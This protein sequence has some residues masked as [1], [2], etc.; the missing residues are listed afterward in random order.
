MKKHTIKLAHLVLAIE[1]NDGGLLAR[2]PTIEG[3]FAE[4]DTVAEAIFNCV[5]VVRMLFE[6]RQ[7]RGEPVLERLS[8]DLPRQKEITF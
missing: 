7:E 5:D 4:G 2:C 8:E 1:R 6:Y 3:A